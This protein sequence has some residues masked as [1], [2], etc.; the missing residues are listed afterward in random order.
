MKKVI[1]RP[2]I[3][4]ARAL[5]DLHNIVLEAISRGRSNLIYVEI[6]SSLRSSQ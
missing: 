5:L 2:H 3:V 4:I 1:A 6:A